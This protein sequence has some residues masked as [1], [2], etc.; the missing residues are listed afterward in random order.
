MSAMVLSCMRAP[1]DWVIRMNG[2]F[3]SMAA[4]IDRTIFQ[5]V[6]TPDTNQQLFF[7]FF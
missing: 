1:P 6:G 3:R 4:L 7:P 2:S 5:T